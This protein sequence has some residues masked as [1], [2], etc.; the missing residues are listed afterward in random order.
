MFFNFLALTQSRRLDD[1][2]LFLPSLPG[3]QNDNST[4]N[5]DANAEK[6]FTLLANF[7]GRRLDDQR[8][9]LPS[10]PGIQNGGTSLPLSPAE[11]NARYLC[12]LVSRA[13]VEHK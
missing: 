10:L 4:S 1:Q 6:L 8:M 11:R 3:L 13:Q 5:G 12:Y 7:Q 2:R 9:F